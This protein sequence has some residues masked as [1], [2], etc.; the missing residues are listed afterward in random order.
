MPAIGCM[1]CAEVPYRPP[2]ADNRRR[3]EAQAWR[4]RTSSS[5]RRIS[6]ARNRR[7][8]PRVRTA[9][10]FPARAQLVKVLGNTEN[11]TATASKSW[12]GVERRS[13]A[14]QVENPLE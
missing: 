7:C 2:P 1:Q 14:E 6:D 10:I 4:S 12:T 8:P 5:N 13:C 9:E 3:R 11:I